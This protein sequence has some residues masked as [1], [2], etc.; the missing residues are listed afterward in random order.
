MMRV[1][2]IFGKASRF[3]PSINLESY[4]K[5]SV[6]ITIILVS[7]A[8]RFHNLPLGFYL[9]EFDPFW[10]YRSAEYIMENG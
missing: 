3:R 9:G 1:R 8:I 4:V 10:H 7:I 2:E 5:T 6:F